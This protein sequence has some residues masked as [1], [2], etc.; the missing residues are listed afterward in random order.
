[1]PSGKGHLQTG[2]KTEVRG[3][4]K[5][6]GS[7]LFLFFFVLYAL[8]SSGNLCGDTEVRWSVARQIVRCNGIKLEDDLRNPNYVIGRD[9]G[10]YSYYNLGQSVLM[11]PFAAL[12]LAI[13]LSGLVNSSAADLAAQFLASVILFPFIGAGLIWLFYRLVLSLGCSL[14]A[15][16]VMSVA[17]G[18]S[19]MILHNSVS[20]QEQTQIAA[21]LVLAV[22]I[23]MRYLKRGGFLYAWLFCLVLGICLLL[24]T[25]SAVMVVPLFVVAVL[26]D[27]FQ[28]TNNNFKKRVAIWLSAGILG[29]GPSLILCGFYNC[30]RFG[31]PYESG[32]SLVAETTM[33]GHTMFESSAIA[34]TGGDAF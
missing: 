3:R 6:P 30:L 23:M 32:Y 2:S 27:I 29:V 16:L 28:R 20:G 1:M 12:G 24:R 33:G 22:L 21:L 10:R 4:S 34:Y 26:A 7:Y 8:F 5:N 25:A 13:E 15:G 17:F 9:G 14:L 19:T 31:C 18:L 11:L